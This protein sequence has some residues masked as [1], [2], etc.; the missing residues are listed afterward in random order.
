MATIERR[1]GIY[2]DLPEEDYHADPALGSPDIN[3]C[4][5]SGPDYWWNSPLNPKRPERKSSPSQE[6]GRALHKLVLEGHQA[7]SVRYVRRP[8]DLVRL[9]A[10]AKAT[11]CPNGET[12]LDGDDFDRI[13]VAGELI[14]KNA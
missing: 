5:A 14:A 9:D 3:Q 13:V 10:R 7:F 11:L 4:R 6:Y 12:V 2:F 1:Q 8:D